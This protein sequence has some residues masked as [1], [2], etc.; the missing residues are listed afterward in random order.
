MLLASA[1]FITFEVV[2]RK[3]LGISTGG[4]D[5]LTGYAFA[6]STSWA[7]S[8]TL[9]RRAHVRVDALYSKMGPNLRAYMDVLALVCMTLFAVIMTYQI[10]NVLSE[11]I[12]LRATA[13]TTMATPLWIP[14]V[15]WV[16]GFVLFSFVAIILSLQCLLLLFS[17]HPEQ[18]QALAGG[19]SV[20]EE[21]VA[22]G[23]DLK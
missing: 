15:L 10:M 23:I 13:N 4:A 21:I 16:F 20:D 19:R 2:I 11:T 5:E 8:F 17:G 6:V 14:Q 1:F 12:T 7:F 18:I 22:E 3:L 9:L